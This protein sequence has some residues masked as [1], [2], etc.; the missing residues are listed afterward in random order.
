M[1]GR[2][3]L[4]VVFITLF[5]LSACEQ[6]KSKKEEG[7]PPTLKS[8]YDWIVPGEDMTFDSSQI[9]MGEVL[10][11]YSDCYQC[12]KKEGEAKGPSFLDIAKRY[13]YQSAYL[14]LLSRKII[15]GGAGVWGYPI[16][17]PHPKVNLEEA[18]SMVTYILSLDPARSK[19]PK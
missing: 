2:F 1:I 4:H 8:S 9:N 5:L 15:S 12:H 13:P 19:R 18:E 6:V 11:S 16:M 10:V 3:K 14:E 17:G 7:L